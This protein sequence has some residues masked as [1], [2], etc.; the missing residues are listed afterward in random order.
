M[1]TE[2]NTERGW[3]IGISRLK[4][5]FEDFKIHLQRVY[6]AFYDELKQN[7]EIS[8][9]IGYVIHHLSCQDSRI[10]DLE[11]DIQKLMGKVDGFQKMF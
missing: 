11:R 7:K 5:R 1:E 9:D 2:K 8:T 4:V 6:E 3:I 10:D